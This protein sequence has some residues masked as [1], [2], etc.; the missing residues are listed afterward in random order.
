MPRVN[1]K[2]VKLN[3]SSSCVPHIR[4]ASPST[5]TCALRRVAPAPRMRQRLLHHP[6]PRLLRPAHISLS[7]QRHAPH[8]R[9]RRACTA[10]RSTMMRTCV[11]DGSP[12]LSAPNTSRHSRACSHTC[13][14]HHPPHTSLASSTPSTPQPGSQH[15]VHTVA[16]GSLPLQRPRARLRH[17]IH[18]PHRTVLL[19]AV[20]CCVID[21]PC[22]GA[23]SSS[24]SAALAC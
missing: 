14:Q 20:G 21:Q 22:L 9:S 4:R 8:R 2:L 12:L 1:C 18:T 17:P 10:I 7:A 6:Q 5:S 16:P 15:A 24:C 23:C 13:F 11:R 3:S 19:L